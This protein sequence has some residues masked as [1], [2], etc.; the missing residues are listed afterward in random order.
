MALWESIKMEVFPRNMDSGISTTKWLWESCHWFRG[1]EAEKWS[2]GPRKSGTLRFP[3]VHPHEHLN[4]PDTRDTRF[5]KKRDPSKVF[6][7]RE[8]KGLSI[9]S[10][11]TRGWGTRKLSW[12][13]SY[14]VIILCPSC[15]CHA[16]AL[17]LNSTSLPSRRPSAPEQKTFSGT[18]MSGGVLHKGSTYQEVCLIWSGSF[19]KRIVKA[20]KGLAA[21]GKIQTL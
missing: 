16:H 6:I 15:S 12:E 7:T 13:R 21:K 18:R 11:V 17:P 4:T 14:V 10:S 20:C 19:R 8:Q 2:P 9:R 3:H 1:D 5:K